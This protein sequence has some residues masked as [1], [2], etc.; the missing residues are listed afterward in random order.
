MAVL[1][2]AVLVQWKRQHY[3]PEIIESIIKWPFISEILIRD[4]S[5]CKNIF[6][7]GRYTL[8]RK[9]K[10]NI[11]YTQDDDCIVHDIGKIYKEFIKHPSIMTTGGTQDY[12][13]VIDENIYGNKQMGL[14]GWG[15]FFQKKWISV[16]NAYTSVYGKDYCFYREPDRIFSILLG[17]HHNLVKADIQL[18]E[19]EDK[20][21]ALCEHPDHLKFK[22]MAIERALKLK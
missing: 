1:V 7:Y 3:L 5:K 22:K 17:K 15:A 13:D 6:C 2:T 20:S 9:A 4:N 11:I 12:L 8:A 16:L 14:M 18:L 10:N 19:D 21:I